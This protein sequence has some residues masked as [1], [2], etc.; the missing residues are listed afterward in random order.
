MTKFS[1]NVGRS[2]AKAITFRLLIL[3]ADGIIIFAI[4]KRY[5]IALTVMF[6]SNLSSTILYFMHER[7]WDRL[8]WGKG[9]MKPEAV[10][11]VKVEH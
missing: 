11:E 1:E 2:L 5:D 6:F 9:N 10:V 7:M 8:N 4:T 3:A